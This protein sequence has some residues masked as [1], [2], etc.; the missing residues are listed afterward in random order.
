MVGVGYKDKILRGSTWYDRCA[1]S[2]NYTDRQGCS[3]F[4]DAIG[5]AGVKKE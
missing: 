3:Q 4:K 2:F 5:G 1:K